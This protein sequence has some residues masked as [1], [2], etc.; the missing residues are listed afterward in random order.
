MKGFKTLLAVMYVFMTVYAAGLQAQTQTQTQT[1]QPK[2]TMGGYMAFSCLAW[3]FDEKHSMTAMNNMHKMSPAFSQSDTNLYFAY[4][5]QNN[6][7]AFTEIKFTY[8]L[9]SYEQTQTSGGI[10]VEPQ[11]STYIDEMLRS[12]D[13]GGIFIERAYME[14]NRY[15]FAKARFG[16]F[17]TPFGIFSQD[18]GAPAIT[19]VRP[20]NLVI[21]PTSGLVS[22]TGMPLYETGVEL[23]GSAS[24]GDFE[25]EYAVYISN[26]PSENPNSNGDNTMCR[27]A[28]LNLIM[29]AMADMV[30]FEFG[31]SVYQG[32]RTYTQ[33][34]AINT[35]TFSVDESRSTD[36][37][38]Q[39]DFITGC[40][41]KTEISGLP[42]EGILLFQAE[43][44]NQK[45]TDQTEY[46]SFTS[47]SAEIEDHNYNV[48][49]AQVE[50]QMLGM[51]T[52]YFRYEDESVS[53]ENTP[54]Y[55]ILIGRTQYVCGLNIKPVPNVSLK[56][57]Y[58]KAI[59]EQSRMA[60][61]LHMNNDYEIYA[62]QITMAFL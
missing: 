41:L 44:L 23:L 34:I 6:W 29:P 53:N 1:E 50:Y 62:F 15:G 22:S 46:S 4:N 11:T 37:L 51:L 30:N 20:P 60:E 14:Y 49:Y 16:R 17:F 55:L 9:K 54:F 25:I 43:Y 24:A 27:G 36:L 45:I 42:L 28:F 8:L 47:T 7:L 26:G 19:S 18:H 10:Y 21:P 59:L 12:Y 3:D 52:P 61:A 2:F 33:T 40:H 38:K 58:Q 39:K 56:F 31:G 48:M 57:E 35:S 5:G 32:K 13:V